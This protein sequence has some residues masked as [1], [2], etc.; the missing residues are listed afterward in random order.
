MTKQTI[1][2]RIAAALGNGATS[3][4]TITKLI[5]ET[6]AAIEEAAAT[7]EQE[8]ARSLDLA[9]VD[10]TQA[11]EAARAAELRRDR[12][13]PTLARLQDKL[14]AALTGERHARWLAD[15]RRVEEEHD[16]LGQKFADVYRR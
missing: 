16:A 3:S 4:A 13:V 12:L 11:D 15:F 1:E 14:S 5:A 10:P 8:R 9:T 7:A 2:E 6:E